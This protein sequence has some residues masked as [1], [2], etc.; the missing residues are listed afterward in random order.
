MGEPLNNPEVTPP[1]I[2][3]R[4]FTLGD[5]KEKLEES[6]VDFEYANKRWKATWQQAFPTIRSY[7]PQDVVSV[8]DI[9]SQLPADKF[10]IA[11]GKGFGFWN[12]PL[13]VVEQLTKSPPLGWEHKLIPEDFYRLRKIREVAQ[14]AEQEYVANLNKQ[15]DKD[16]QI[17]PTQ[18]KT[19]KDIWNVYNVNYI[20]RRANGTRDENFSD[21]SHEKVV[22]LAER[23]KG[24][25]TSPVFTVLDSIVSRSLPQSYRTLL[26]QYFFEWYGSRD[27]GLPWQAK[28]KYLYPDDQNP[29]GSI[30]CSQ[31]VEAGVLRE[32]GFSQEGF[33]AYNKFLNEIS[34]AVNNAKSKSIQFA[35]NG[36]EFIV[37][38][39]AGYRHYGQEDPFNN[40]TVEQEANDIG[41]FEKVDGKY[42]LRVAIPSTWRTL[43]EKYNFYEYGGAFAFGPRELL[44]LFISSGEAD[45]RRQEFNQ[46]LLEIS[47]HS[48]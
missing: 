6:G 7:L 28:F 47:K 29:T 20:H 41:I 1:L 40:Q 23:F 37:K 43:A 4:E 8:W 44:P 9:I 11:L 18:I 45:Q 19:I 35:Y 24:M 48:S 22:K 13:E 42:K 38:L 3:Q 27:A 39:G 26:E 14:Q 33:S 2:E 36:R 46:L 25:R 34:R 17:T 30:H 32:Y 31:E 16:D 10:N 21:E 12:L 15:R 5:F